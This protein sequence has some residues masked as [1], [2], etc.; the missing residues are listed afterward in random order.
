ML[1]KGYDTEYKNIGYRV[2]D[3]G[4]WIQNTEIQNRIQRTG[5]RILDTE[6]RNTQYIMQ[7]KKISL[8]KKRKF[9]HFPAPVPFPGENINILQRQSLSF[10]P[11]KNNF[12]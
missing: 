11:F 12:I 6:Y 9:R 10:I 1:Y 8:Y 7:I 5:Y 4:Y 2:Q 3:I